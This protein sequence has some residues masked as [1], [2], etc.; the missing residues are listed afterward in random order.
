MDQ[1]IHSKL[2]YRYHGVSFFAIAMKLRVSSSRCV[3]DLGSK[4][5]GNFHS[6]RKEK[7]SARRFSFVLKGIPHKHVIIYIYIYIY[8]FLYAM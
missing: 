7:K 1:S 4:Q 3:K 5:K 2:P 8:I 6:H